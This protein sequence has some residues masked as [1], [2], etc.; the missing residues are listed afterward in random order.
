MARSLIITHD[1]DPST[2]WL[3]T[4]FLLVATAWLLLGG[5]ASMYFADDAGTEEAPVVQAI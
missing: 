1:E 3:L 4:G 5:L 2:N